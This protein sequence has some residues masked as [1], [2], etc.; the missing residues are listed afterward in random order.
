M[1]SV[2]VGGRCHRDD[3]R[4]TVFFPPSGV[5]RD[6]KKSLPPRSMPNQYQ[7]ISFS[8]LVAWR[9][10]KNQ[11]GFHV[12]PPGRTGRGDIICINVTRWGGKDRASFVSHYLNAPFPL[13]PRATANCSFFQPHHMAICGAA[14]NTTPIMQIESNY[15]RPSPQYEIE[16]HFFFC[17]HSP[18]PPF[19]RAITT[20]RKAHAP[21]PAAT[22]AGFF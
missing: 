5:A 2:R 3:K 19:L 16:S 17:Q 10:S 9:E 12:L 11:H 20:T 22:Y 18:P 21:I 13:P 1:A 7:K 15:D 6:T 14:A 4:E 8:P